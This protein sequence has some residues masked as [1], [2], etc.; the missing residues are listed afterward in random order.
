M[1]LS[2]I[3][4]KLSEILKYKLN[5]ASYGDKFSL[6]PREIQ[7]AFLDAG[8]YDV[9]LPTQPPF[10]TSRFQKNAERQAINKKYSLRT[11]NY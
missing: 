3:E 2:D 7:S 11:L 9:V 8:Y 4:E 1:R 10:T 5:C 6:K